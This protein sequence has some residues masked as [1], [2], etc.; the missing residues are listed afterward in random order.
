MLAYRKA[1]QWRA[2]EDVA[3]Q[4]AIDA[5]LLVRPQDDRE[6]AM[7]QVARAIAYAATHHT[8]WFWRGVSAI[9]GLILLTTP[10]TAATRCERG[11]LIGPV[12]HVRDGDTIEVG[13]LPVRLE[14]LAAPELDEPGGEEATEAMRMLVEGQEVR[15]ELTGERSGDRCIGTCYLGGTDI[16]AELVRAGVARDCPRFSRGR[17]GDEEQQAARG[18]ATIRETYRLPESCR[19]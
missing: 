17:Y 18:G 7:R 1:R 6:E 3:H 9:V 10:A 14:G 16:A 12:T 5:Y 8:A 19:R 4:A 11:P 15:C 2:G 13:G